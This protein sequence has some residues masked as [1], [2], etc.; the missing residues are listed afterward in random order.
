MRGVPTN[1]RLQYLREPDQ[2]PARLHA[3]HPPPPLHKG[4]GESPQLQAEV[5]EGQTFDPDS[6]RVNTPAETGNAGGVISL[7]ATV[8]GEAIPSLDEATKDALARAKVLVEATGGDLGGLRDVNVGV[9][10]VTAPNSTDVSDYGV[11]DTST[12]RKDVTAVVNV[13]FA[14]AG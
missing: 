7:L 6:V 12:I 5:A 8:S 11:Y 3:P 4:E 14:L 10:Q 13:S 9:F 1:R 2:A